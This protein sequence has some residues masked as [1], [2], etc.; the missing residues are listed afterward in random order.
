MLNVDFTRASWEGGARPRPLVAAS[1]PYA[2]VHHDVYPASLPPVEHARAIERQHLAQGWNGSFYN[3]GLDRDGKFWELRGYGWRSIGSHAARYDDGT[4]V[5]PAALTVVL[6]GNYEY[7]AL[8]PAQRVGLDKVRQTVPDQR[9]RWHRM[10]A[11]TACP[12]SNAVPVLTEIN[13]DTPQEAPDM[14]PEQA[15]QLNDLHFALVGARRFAGDQ[16]HH[17]LA[18]PILDTNHAAQVT[19]PTRLAS[20]AGQVSQVRALAD[21]AATPAEVAQVIDDALAGL[22]DA[23]EGLPVD[24]EPVDR[25]TVRRLLLDL[26]GAAA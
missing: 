15:D 20:M 19:L 26:L 21:A 13:A 8:T 25:E 17:D 14:T 6:F 4:P 3:L 23:I 5:N 7:S 11:A 24:G 1:H 22:I 10:R 9:L 12:G 18:T 2:E 16:R